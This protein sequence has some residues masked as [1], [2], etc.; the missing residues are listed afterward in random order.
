MSEIQKTE[1]KENTITEL[2]VLYDDNSTLFDKSKY[3]VPLYQRAFA[4]EDKEI[5]QLI[6][7]I[8]DCE[9]NVSHY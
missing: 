8:N 6:E 3:I 5:R 4:W 9:S 1:N 2:Q 7:D